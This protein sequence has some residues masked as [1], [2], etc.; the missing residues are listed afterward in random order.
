MYN[1]QLTGWYFP[2]RKQQGERVCTLMVYHLHDPQA[3]TIASVGDGLNNQ[4]TEDMNLCTFS[5]AHVFAEQHREREREASTTYIACVSMGRRERNK[6][7]TRGEH[8][9]TDLVGYT[10][11]HQK[12]IPHL[13]AEVKECWTRAPTQKCLA[14]GKRCHSCKCTALSSLVVW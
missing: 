13:T 9:R 5:N 6:G 3:G 1:M 2:E 7:Q 11:M 8:V 10:T 12:Q 14:N 4:R